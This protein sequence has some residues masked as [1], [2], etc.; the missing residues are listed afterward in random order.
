MGANFVIRSTDAAGNSSAPAT[1]VVVRDTVAP[2]APEAA[3]EGATVV[4]GIAVVP[5]RRATLAGRAEPGAS[6]EA[7]GPNLFN[8]TTAGA[9]GA[10]RLVVTLSAPF[11]PVSIDVEAV[12]AAGN[13]SAATVLRVMAASGGFGGGGGEG[14]AR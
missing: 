4:N 11:V 1:L 6:V 14:G 3:V 10:F 5:D 13:R 2:D 7:S 9:D 8:V 12:D